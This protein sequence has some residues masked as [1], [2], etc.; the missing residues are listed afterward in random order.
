MNEMMSSG[1]EI[2]WLGMTIVF[3]FLAMLIIAVNLMSMIIQRFY[4]QETKQQITVIN[5]DPSVIAAISVAIHQYRNK[6]EL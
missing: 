4:P 1:L 2:M 3:L 5:N 6:Y